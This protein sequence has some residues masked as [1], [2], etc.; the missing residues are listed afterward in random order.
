MDAYYRNDYPEALSYFSKL[1]S[2]QP[3]GK[4]KREYLRKAGEACHRIA[5]EWREERRL[6]GAAKAQSI[7]EQ[8]KRML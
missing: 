7:A 6:K 3:D 8:M 2:L 5:S 1:S 4:L